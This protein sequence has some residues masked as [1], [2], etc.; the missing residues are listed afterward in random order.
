[1]WR[2]TAYDEADYAA[3]REAGLTVG[4]KARF[5]PCRLPRQLCLRGSGD[6]GKSLTSLTHSLRVGDGIGASGVVLH[7]GSAKK[8]EV[9]G[10]IARAGDVISQALASL[11]AASCTSRTPPA[12]AARWGAPS[13]SWRALIEAAG[14][15]ARLGALSRLLPPAGLRL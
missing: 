15:D 9:K 1:M 14:A 6:P 4:R 5:D 7:A 8:G 2:P 12:R 3:F 10:A 13:R 11:S